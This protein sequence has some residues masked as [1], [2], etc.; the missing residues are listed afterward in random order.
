MA[1]KGM[2]KLLMLGGIY[3]G[4]AE[5]MFGGYTERPN[6]DISQL[7][8]SEEERLKEK[9]K[10]DAIRFDRKKKINQGLTEFHYGQGRSLWA[11]TQKSA[12][13]KAVKKGWLKNT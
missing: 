5:E 11:R 2:M 8:K 3:A 13:K 9:R 1:G 6:R 12:D 4:A 10:I 7:S